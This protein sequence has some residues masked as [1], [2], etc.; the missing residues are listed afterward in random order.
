MFMFAAGFT[1]AWFLLG[2]FFYFREGS[3]SWSIWGH[4]YNDAPRDSCYLID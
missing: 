3:G 1:I 4:N 2:I